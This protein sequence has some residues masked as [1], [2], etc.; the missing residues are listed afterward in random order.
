[1]IMKRNSRQ[2]FEERRFAILIVDKVTGYP[3]DLAI[4]LELSDL[5]MSK[6]CCEIEGN[7]TVATF[8][9]YQV[10]FQVLPISLS[11]CIRV[12]TTGALENII[13]T[14]NYSMPTIENVPLIYRP[15]SIVPSILYTPT[16]TPLNI[17]TAL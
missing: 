10:S 6:A 11:S 13:Y 9:W 12:I 1:M 4:A 2:P 15:C 3:R 5:D 8:G 17:P 7:T 14:I 16:R